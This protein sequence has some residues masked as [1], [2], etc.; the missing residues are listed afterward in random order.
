VGLWYS[1]HVLT[2]SS[3]FVNKQELDIQEQTLILQEELVM[4]LRQIDTPSR[5]SAALKLKSMDDKDEVSKI[6]QMEIAR[7]DASSKA[8]H[9]VK[10]VL[11]QRISEF[12]LSSNETQ[13]EIDSLIKALNRLDGDIKMLE[14]KLDAKDKQ[15]LEACTR[16][17]KAEK[18]AV[19]LKSLVSTLQSQVNS[20]TSVIDSSLTQIPIRQPSRLERKNVS[21]FTPRANEGDFAMF[22][23]QLDSELDVLK[24]QIDLY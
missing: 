23:S 10:E 5:A 15:Y 20:P 14:D 24:K 11:E 19:Q 16:A 2:E 12:M 18:E 3:L 9:K 17:E 13:E 22:E 21:L 8:L 7:L 4:L 1:E 6:V